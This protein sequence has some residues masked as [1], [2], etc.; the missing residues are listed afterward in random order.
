M[1]RF[2]KL[3]LKPYSTWVL[4]FTAASVLTASV[5]LAARR[6]ANSQRDQLVLVQNGA[7]YGEEQYYVVAPPLIHVYYLK[8][9][10]PRSDSSARRNY[11]HEI[12]GLAN[13]RWV[14][15]R[16]GISG[17][18][19]VFLNADHCDANNQLDLSSD[20]LRKAF[21]G[22]IRIKDIKA[23]GDYSIAIYSEIPGET[24]YSLRAAL[25]HQEADGWRLVQSVFAGEGF[26][27]CGTAYFPMVSDSQPQSFILLVYTSAMDPTGHDFVNIQSLLI[28]RPE[29]LPQQR[30]K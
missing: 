12:F 19:D 2:S 20:S 28:K 1:R 15:Q 14:I 23:H 8:S 29:P 16:H 6:A 7:F 13:D 10:K 17:R 5:I 22:T 9:G 3:A 27:F 25:L 26:P 11:V 4:C 21:P 18:P 30:Q 24:W